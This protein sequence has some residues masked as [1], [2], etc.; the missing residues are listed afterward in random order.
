MVHEWPLLDS[1]ND[2]S[3]GI[4]SSV[5]WYGEGMAVYHQALLPYKYGVFDRKQFLRELNNIAS[6]YYTS[7][8]IGMDDDTADRVE[9]H[10]TIEVP[11]FYSNST[12]SFELHL[13][14]RVHSMN[15]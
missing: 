4:K 15:Q 5:A 11:C 10:H 8:A 13:E 12:L 9:W 3:R 6:A 14:K 1:G 7:P 2:L